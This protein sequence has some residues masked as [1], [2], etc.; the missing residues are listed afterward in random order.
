VA[1]SDITEYFPQTHTHKIYILLCGTFSKIGHI[2][3]HKSSF[4]RYKKKGITP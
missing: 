2:A 1:L 3:G 4:S